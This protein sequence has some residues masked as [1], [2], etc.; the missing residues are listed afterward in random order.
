MFVKKNNNLLFFINLICYT[1]SGDGIM[2]NSSRS[3]IKCLKKRTGLTSSSFNEFNK[4]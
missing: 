3:K 4:E 2:L 1:I